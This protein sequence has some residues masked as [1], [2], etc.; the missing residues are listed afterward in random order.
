MDH[1]KIVKGLECC[2]EPGGNCNAC[3]Y[4][5]SGVKE[6]YEAE[7]ESKLP[8]DALALIKEQDK[9]IE[10]YSKADEFL[11]AHGWRWEKI[12]I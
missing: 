4:N 3:P 10:K 12:G 8:A 5:H 6:Y 7:C 9:I 11:A 2:A 1:D